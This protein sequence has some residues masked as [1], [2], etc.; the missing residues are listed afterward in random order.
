MN[1][2]FLIHLGIF[3]LGPTEII[4]IAIV[5]VI[6]FG[7]RL[8]EVARSL[9]KSFFDF[10]RNLKDLQDDIYRAEVPPPRH[11]PKPYYPREENEDPKA[12]DAQALPR[13]KPDA[14]EPHE[15]KDRD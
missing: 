10:K 5:A 8:P 11:L 4:V 14:D 3:N 12:P 9:G 13:E 7:G 15:T 1:A 6:L 2:L